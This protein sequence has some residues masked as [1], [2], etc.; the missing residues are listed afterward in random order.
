M[1]LVDTCGLLACANDT[2][3]DASLTALRDEAPEGR[4]ALSVA[5][6]EIACKHATGK[7]P[8]ALPPLEAFE[9]ICFLLRLRVVDLDAATG[10][11]AAALPT[12]HRDPS[13]RLMIAWALAHDATVITSDRVWPTYGVRT[14]WTKPAVLRRAPRKK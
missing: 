3:P 5:A 10:C 9:R 4:V 7:L 14:M 12:H 13:D 11:K 6:W 1:I 8:L 2:L